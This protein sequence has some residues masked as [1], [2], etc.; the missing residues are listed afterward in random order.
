MSNTTDYI[1]K[2]TTTSQPTPPPILTLEELEKLTKEY[3]K[4]NP[5]P[6]PPPSYYTFTST[7]QEPT[8]QEILNSQLRKL[9]ER[10]KKLHLIKK[11]IDIDEDIIE[12]M[13]K[14]I[15]TKILNLYLEKD[16]GNNPSEP[17]D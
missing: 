11:H 8:Q 12:A 7:K 4:W 5:A 1:Y 9:Q 16:L 15:Q 14:D 17:I 3:L 6:P 10:R 13:D 2:N